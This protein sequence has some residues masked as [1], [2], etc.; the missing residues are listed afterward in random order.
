MKN[1]VHS[2][3]D[4]DNT[5]FLSPNLNN[6]TEIRIDFKE[7]ILFKKDIVLK[8]EKIWYSTLNRSS[9]N[10]L[11]MWS[12]KFDKYLLHTIEEISEF[13]VEI[14]NSEINSDD[15][16]ILTDAMLEELVDVIGYL[17]STL[18]LMK[19]ESEFSW[20]NDD[21]TYKDAFTDLDKTSKLCYI[22][23]R[24]NKTLN[25]FQFVDVSNRDNDTIDLYINSYL[26][27]YCLNP[28]IKA[29]RQ[30]PERKW[31][32]NVKRELSLNSLLNLFEEVQSSLSEVMV[33]CIELFLLL[34]KNDYKK[35]N[36]IYLEKGLTAYRKAEN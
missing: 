4:N 26:T 22:D 31:H 15:K 27:K 21:I 9:Y 1:L 24:S 34:T 3:K 7:M 33:N 23:I 5:K 30:F 6:T 14:G 25:F 28:L 2:N 12:E 11:Q 32:K 17:A 13:S 10:Y 19:R 8:Y 18:Y 36:T 35:F 16:F 20:N 29:R